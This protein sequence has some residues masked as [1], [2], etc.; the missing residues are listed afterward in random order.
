MD[1]SFV[2]HLEDRDEWLKIVRETLPANFEVYPA[3]SLEE[4]AET[5]R[6][7]RSD[8]LNFDAAIIDLSL[9]PD[10]AKNKDGFVLI[11]QL[12]GL[13]LLHEKSIIVL[14]GFEEEDDNLRV[15]FRDYDVKDVFTKLMFSEEKDQFVAA[16]RQACDTSKSYRRE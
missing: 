9:L 16:V 4:A 3:K 2:L 12:E 7:F 15:A 11:N 13:N 8:G 1:S 10:D 5:I 14:T 6:D